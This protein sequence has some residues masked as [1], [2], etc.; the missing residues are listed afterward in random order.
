MDPL[1]RTGPLPTGAKTTT[2]TSS[3]TPTRV[4]APTWATSSTGAAA[5]PPAARYEVATKPAEKPAPTQGKATAAG[6]VFSLRLGSSPA[7]G[8]QAALQQPPDTAAA[9]VTFVT[10]S[11]MKRDVFLDVAKRYGVSEAA[12]RALW[13]QS[14]EASTTDPVTGFATNT[15]RVETLQAAIDHV[16]A[17]GGAAAYV[18][19]ELVNLAGMNGALGATGANE[20]FGSLA[21]SFRWETTSTGGEASWY[22]NGGA[23]VSAVVVGGDP[24]A[25]PDAMSRVQASFSVEV[26]ARGLADVDH[27]KHVGDERFQ[28][29]SFT[30]GVSPIGAGDDVAGV[31]TRADQDL[32]ARAPLVRPPPSTREPPLAH[33]ELVAVPRT[34]P[35]PKPRTPDADHMSFTGGLDEWRTTF[36]AA[37][38][39]AGATPGGAVALWDA[40]GV[41]KNATDAVTGFQNGAKRVRTLELAQ[42]HT[43]KT[44]D[45]AV[46]V[47]MDVRNLSGLNASLGRERANTAF[48]FVAEAV[49]DELKTLDAKVESFRH[50][51]D[52][53][54]FILVSS[55]AERADVAAAL[56]RA[57]ARV[58]AYVRQNGLSTIEH[59]KHPGDAAFAGTGIVTGTA[60][61]RPG[62]DVDAVFRAADVEV[63]RQKKIGAS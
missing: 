63:E 18:E 54:S 31:L 36:L 39:A 3:P 8:A 14:G 60:L 49:R 6:T 24:A 22:R 42:A 21:Q 46:Y 43:A 5:P 53:L 29:V 26:D 17:F 11:D 41:E 10:A 50:G 2:T 44:G 30:F 20:L 32:F 40:S 12:A 45:L 56:Q 7:G 58:K 61:I 9:N 1:R 28:G 35:K 52:E 27:P 16:A 33:K 37:A 48:R 23:V 25:L 51:G 59:P 19:G 47:E 57:Q 13:A 38:R 34:G 4:Q 62:D 55:T 15:D